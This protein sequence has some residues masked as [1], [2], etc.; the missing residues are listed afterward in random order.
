[1][2]KTKIYNFGKLKK[3]FSAYVQNGA[4]VGRKWFNSDQIC[5]VK[6][7]RSKTQFQIFSIKK[8]NHLFLKSR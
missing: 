5:F 3:S 8:L 6:V 7:T 1:M 4:H 2:D